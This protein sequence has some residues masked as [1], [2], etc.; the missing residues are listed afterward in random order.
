L[1]DRLGSIE[2]PSLVIA[3]A[4]DA[5]GT[6]RARVVAA[7]LPDARLEVIDGAGHAPHLERPDDFGSLVSTFLST[8]RTQRPY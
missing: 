3:G 4:L 6:E 2:C 5:A 7:G 8:L 1:H